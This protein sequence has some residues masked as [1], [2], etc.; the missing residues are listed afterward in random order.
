MLILIQPGIRELLLHDA[1]FGCGTRSS[2]NLFTS[3]KS[4]RWEQ[5][6][7]A[8]I[9]Q[10]GNGREGSAKYEGKKRSGDANAAA[11]ARKAQTIVRHPNVNQIKVMVQKQNINGNDDGRSCECPRDDQQPSC[12]YLPP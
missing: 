11:K 3:C 4:E 9:E 8:Q 2:G 5:K 1:F 10:E 7:T 12:R 6:K